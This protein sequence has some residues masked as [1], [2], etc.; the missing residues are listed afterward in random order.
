M[1]SFDSTL[2]APQPKPP[3]KADLLRRAAEAGPGYRGRRAALTRK[4]TDALMAALEGDVPPYLERPSR[5]VDRRAKLFQAGDYPDKGVAVTAADL[6]RLADEFDLPVPVLIEHAES[7]LELGYLTHVEAS[8]SELF[9]NLALTEEAHALAEKSGA[10]RISIG[11]DRG[12]S[13]I[14]EVSLVRTPRIPDAQ[15]FGDDVRFWCELDAS[16]SENWKAKYDELADRFRREEVE[17]EVGRLVSEGKLLPAQVPFARV[18]LE[19]GDTVVFDGDTKPIHAIAQALFD[20]QKPHGL[21]SEL[22]PV[23]GSAES[24]FLPEEAAFYRKHFPDVS[25]EVIAAKKGR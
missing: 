14:R 18:L 13:R 17:A 8:G 3:A 5:W 16:S 4:E 1:K 24:L 2:L 12:L 15:M 11:L 25:L 10:R 9:G 20:L 22:A 6:R 19:A 7:P 21:L 23:A